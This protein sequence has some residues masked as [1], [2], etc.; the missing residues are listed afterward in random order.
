MKFILVYFRTV[1][2]LGYFNVLSVIVYRA[3]IRSFIAKLVFLQKKKKIFTQAFFQDSNENKTSVLK[4]GLI[5]QNADSILDG[6]IFYYSYHLLN[7]GQTPNWFINPFNGITYKGINQHWT[8]LNDFDS[9]LGDIKNVWELSRFNWLGTL[10][11]AYKISKNFTY[12]DKM[13][14]WV[15]D[16]IEKNPQ[17]TG[18]NWKCGQEA[19]LRAINILLSNEILK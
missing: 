9:K 1:K 3:F 7:V 17:N 12:L 16:W 18:P 8:K 10:A 13:N 11:I 6:N 19:S 2:K 15:Q 5:L 14:Q 4:N